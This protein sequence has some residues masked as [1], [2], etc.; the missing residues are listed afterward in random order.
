MLFHQHGWEI[1]SDSPVLQ[2]IDYDVGLHF[3]QQPQELSFQER[4]TLARV[5]E[6]GKLSRERDR[7]ND[8]VRGCACWPDGINFY[9]LIP[10]LT[11]STSLCLFYD[12]GGDNFRFVAYIYPMIDPFSTG[13]RSQGKYFEYNSMESSCYTKEGFGTT[14]YTKL[15]S[16]PQVECGREAWDEIVDFWK[17]EQLGGFWP[18]MCH[19]FHCASDDSCVYDGVK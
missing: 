1:D 17:M 12:Y 7:R 8:G 10:Y 3:L 19:F 5:D 9:D 14:I 6:Y 11:Y 13:G 15:L 18:G 16:D 4:R 2:L